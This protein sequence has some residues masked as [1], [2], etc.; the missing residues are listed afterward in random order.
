MHTRG[1]VFP[2]RSSTINRLPRQD[3]VAPIP[4]Q[5]ILRTFR[6]PKAFSVH[7]RRR[8]RFLITIAVCPCDHAIVS[9]FRNVRRIVPSRVRPSN[10][11][12]VVV[13]LGRRYRISPLV[14]NVRRLKVLPRSFRHR[15]NREVRCLQVVSTRTYLGRN[16]QGK[17]CLRAIRASRHI[18]GRD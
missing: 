18:Q 6:I 12:Q 11:C 17:I 4:C 10:L 16:L 8:Q 2:N 7:V 9:N 15:I 1:K 14:T 13:N 3:E 5:R